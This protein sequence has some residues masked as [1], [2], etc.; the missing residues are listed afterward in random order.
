MDARDRLEPSDASFGDRESLFEH[1]LAVRSVSA[2]R[3]HL[4]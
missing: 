2:H 1:P 3:P 4:A